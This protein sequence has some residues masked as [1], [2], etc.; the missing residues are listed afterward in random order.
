[1]TC[2]DVRD[3]LSEHA[4]GTLDEAEDQRIRRHLRG[5]AQCRREVAAIG[6]GL[7]M[8][9]AAAHDRT[10]PDE[11]RDRTLSVLA[12]EW[13]QDPVV[14]SDA[15]RGRS[16][17][18]LV[19]VAACVALAI[20]SVWTVSVRVDARDD[21]AD[22]ASYQRLLDTLGGEEFRVAALE[23]AGPV[24]I[25]GSVVLYD[26]SVEQSWGVVLV[27]APD[28][29]GSLGVTLSTADGRTIELHE[30]EL[31]SGSGA[32]WLVS[33]EDLHPYDRLTITGPDGETLATARITEA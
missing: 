13:R 1:V 31:Q 26:S 4:L 33:A 12:E 30:A 11:L 2:D 21:V 6:D 14:L 8:F 25:D 29:T 28:L 32:T 22:A 20:V 27:R 10:P 3:R 17:A 24:R 15:G 18:W 19:A 23:P 7:A 9:A 5:C 16:R